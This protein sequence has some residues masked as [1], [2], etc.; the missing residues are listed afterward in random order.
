[1][2]AYKVCIHAECVFSIL[3]VPGFPQKVGKPLAFIM[4]VVA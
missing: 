2:A 1:M 4:I 3:R